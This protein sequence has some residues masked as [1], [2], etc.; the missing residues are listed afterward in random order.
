[1]SDSNWLN[2][3]LDR[4]KRE[5]QSWD[6]WKRDAMRRVAI[7]IAVGREMP[8]AETSEVRPD[9]PQSVSRLSKSETL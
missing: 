7:S 1:M 5:V 8:H 2:V 9:D 3:Q 6:E 4:A